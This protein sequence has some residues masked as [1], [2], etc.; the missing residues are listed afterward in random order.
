MVFLVMQT[1]KKLRAKTLLGALASLLGAKTLL[2]PP[3][4]TTRNKNATSKLAPT[5]STADIFSLSSKPSAAAP[6]ASGTRFP[7]NNNVELKRIKP[8]SSGRR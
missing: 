6:S 2:G 3:G 7:A 8:N 5:K 4:L 1:R